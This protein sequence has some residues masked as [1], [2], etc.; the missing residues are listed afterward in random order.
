LGDI[1]GRTSAATEKGGAR[2]RKVGNRKTVGNGGK[3][4]RSA[5][6]AGRGGTGLQEDRKIECRTGERQLAALYLLT[7]QW[8]CGPYGKKYLL[9]TLTHITLS[10][11]GNN[12]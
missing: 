12:N 2:D 1:A 9:T 10:E 7:C 11:K 6:R 4:A 8:E 5:G 3:E